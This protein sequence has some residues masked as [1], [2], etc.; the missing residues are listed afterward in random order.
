MCSRKERDENWARCISYS[1]FMGG[2]SV[3][4][5]TYLCEWLQNHLGLVTAWA[6]LPGWRKNV[7]WVGI[8]PCGIKVTFHAEMHTFV[9]FVRC[10]P[11]C[12]MCR[13]LF[14]KLHN[15]KFYENLFCASRAFT[16]GLTQRLGEAN[17]LFFAISLWTRQ[18]CCGLN[19][20]AEGRTAFVHL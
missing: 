13:Q 20:Q 9:C 12:W 2:C 11:N 17:G 4:A 5:F 16:S 7:V 10:W 8:H 14:E 15:L 3:K 6:C 18:K 19:I 1:S